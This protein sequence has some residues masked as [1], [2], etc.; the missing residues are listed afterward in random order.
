[1]GRIVDVIL[2][3]DEKVA[4]IVKESLESNG[5]SVN[6]S[7]QESP[8]PKYSTY[9]AIKLTVTERGMYESRMAPPAPKRRNKGRV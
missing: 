6:K 8:T 4:H 1:M 2:V 3:R 7:Y 5:Y 9:D